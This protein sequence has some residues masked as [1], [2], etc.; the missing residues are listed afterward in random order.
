MSSRDRKIIAN[1]GELTREKREEIFSV[2]RGSIGPDDR[3]PEEV[4]R[5]DF[6]GNVDGYLRIMAGMHGITI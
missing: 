4:I 6:N 5:D 3:L 2:I 1:P